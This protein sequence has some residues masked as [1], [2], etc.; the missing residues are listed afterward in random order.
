[1]LFKQSFANNIFHKRFRNAMLLFATINES[2]NEKDNNEKG[3][4]I[5][6]QLQRIFFKLEQID[7]KAVRTQLLLK[8]FGWNNNEQ[9]N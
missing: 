3:I 1:M 8:A 7:G 2:Q 4:Q 9:N 6:K 5:V